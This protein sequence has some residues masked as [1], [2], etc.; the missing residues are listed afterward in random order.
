MVVPK[1]EKMQR[2]A[3][4][5]KE[6]AQNHGYL[7]ENHEG[8][9]GASLSTKTARQV[10]KILLRLK[11]SSRCGVSTENNGGPWWL[12]VA[13]GDGEEAWDVGNGFGRKKEKEMTFF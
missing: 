11:G 9:T 1:S 2:Q 3:E 7:K 4:T 5:K 10:W 6:Q 13:M 12:L 8:Q